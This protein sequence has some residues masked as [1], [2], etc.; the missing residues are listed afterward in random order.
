ML[1][2]EL[3]FQ[4]LQEMSSN[5]P[6]SLLYFAAFIASRFYCAAAE[7]PRLCSYPRM[8]LTDG[9]VFRVGCS[10]SVRS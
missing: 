10:E 9:E 4:T 3:S 7:L 5:T 8:R 1:F 2:E 6:A